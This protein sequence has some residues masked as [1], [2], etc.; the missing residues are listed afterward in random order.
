[1]T[2]ESKSN[3]ITL[4]LIWDRKAFC[5]R[6]SWEVHRQSSHRGAACRPQR[7]SSQEP[8]EIHHS[9]CLRC[10]LMKGY[11]KRKWFV[12]LL[13]FTGGINMED[14]LEGEYMEEP[15]RISPSLFWKCSHSQEELHS[16]RGRPPFEEGG[17][18]GLGEKIFTFTFQ[19]EAVQNRSAKSRREASQQ[20]GLVS[21]R[22]AGLPKICSSHRPVEHLILQ[23]Y[24][25]GPARRPKLGFC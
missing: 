1:M 17:S 14:T 13:V 2:D 3:E 21:G 8:V 16:P 7:L 11:L 24:Q 19:C 5:S 10:V 4:T 15:T 22:G 12:L 20:V 18:D 6:S 25:T 9:L 23:T